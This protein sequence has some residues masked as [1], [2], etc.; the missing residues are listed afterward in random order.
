MC[1]QERIHTLYMYCTYSTKTLY[2]G[3]FQISLFFMDNPG[4]FFAPPFPPKEDMN[5]KEV[6]GGS[7]KGG[8]VAK[9]HPF[10]VGVGVG[11]G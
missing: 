7:G 11:G 2:C 4:F 9:T 6:R 10:G 8:G 5:D 3:R 1:L